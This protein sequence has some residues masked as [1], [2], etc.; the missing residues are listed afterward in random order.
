MNERERAGKAPVVEA[1][2][3]KW[4]ENALLHNRCST[5]VAYRAGTLK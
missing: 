1:A 4:I 3:V 5:R 2:L